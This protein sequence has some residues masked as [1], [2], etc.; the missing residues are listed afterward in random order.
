MC[1]DPVLIMAHLSFLEKR[2]SS[3][4]GLCSPGGNNPSVQSLHRTRLLQCCGGG[5]LRLV[6]KKGQMHKAL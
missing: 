1:Q 5:E 2:A 3:E 4:K 6:K